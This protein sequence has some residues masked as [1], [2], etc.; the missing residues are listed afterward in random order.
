MRAQVG[1][2][3]VRIHNV[4]VLGS[5]QDIPD[6]VK[7]LKINRVVIAM[8]TAPGKEIREIVAICEQAG[9]QTKIIPGIYELLDGTV[10]V[11]QQ[12]DVDIEDLLRRDS[13]QTDIVAVQALI[14]GKRVLVTGGG[15]RRR[16]H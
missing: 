12:R 5:R 4:P 8:P 2:H 9:V 14:R 3:D 15:G 6:T 13:V 1:K 7:E 16:A 11:N 10:S